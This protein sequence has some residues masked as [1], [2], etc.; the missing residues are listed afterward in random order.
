MMMIFSLLWGEDRGEGCYLPTPETG[1]D[2]FSLSPPVG[3]R[4]GVRG[5][6]FPTGRGDD[7]FLSLP[8]GGES[9]GEGIFFSHRERELR[10][11]FSLSPVGRG[12]G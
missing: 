11:I 8:C 9:W 10:I 2:D 3:E 4:A 7:D 5:C 12:L 6:S 1:D